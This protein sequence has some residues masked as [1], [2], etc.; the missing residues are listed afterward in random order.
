MVRSTATVRRGSAG[1]RVVSTCESATSQKAARVKT[2]SLFG[3]VARDEA[4]TGSDVD[5]LVEL[6][7]PP[8]FDRHIAP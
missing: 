6:E 4:Q 5:V 2:L 8:N 1:V 3:S 7:G